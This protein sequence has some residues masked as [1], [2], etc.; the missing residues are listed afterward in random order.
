MSEKLLDILKPQG[1][2]IPEQLLIRYAEG[3][4]SS[5][6]ARKVEEHISECEF[7]SDALDG[8]M[9]NGNVQHFHSQLSSIKKIVHK[10]VR[11]REASETFPLMRTLGVAATLL[12]IAISA[13]YVEYVV[14]N[15]S[16]K[17]F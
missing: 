13:W 14:N 8:I 17:I 10:K 9:Q 2:C 5:A 3:K 4:L 1:A 12:V 7:C 16:Q 11:S 6:E 15:N